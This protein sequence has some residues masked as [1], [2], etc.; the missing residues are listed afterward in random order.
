MYGVVHEQQTKHRGPSSGSCLL[1]QSRFQ[2]LRFLF[3]EISNGSLLQRSVGGT[4][5]V[6]LRTQRTPGL[7]TSLL[8]SHGRIRIPVALRSTIALTVVR[9]F[10][11]RRQ[12]MA[13]LQKWEPIQRRQTDIT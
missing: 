12:V 10:Q 8:T 9:L 5:Q 13:K 4:V 3:L 2:T 7:T 1:L 11:S 6:R